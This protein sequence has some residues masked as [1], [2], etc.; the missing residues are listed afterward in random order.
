MLY[1]ATLIGRL[2]TYVL[3]SMPKQCFEQLHF[4]TTA[5]FFVARGDKAYVTD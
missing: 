1:L 3:Y 5:E 2:V 4:H